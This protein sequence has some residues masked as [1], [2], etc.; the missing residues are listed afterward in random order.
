MLGPTSTYV[1]ILVFNFIYL[2]KSL[3]MYQFSEVLI[4]Q[5]I[6]MKYCVLVHS[7]ALTRPLSDLERC[8]MGRS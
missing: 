7:R 4:F 1:V 3:I 8:N 2:L 6:E 5:I